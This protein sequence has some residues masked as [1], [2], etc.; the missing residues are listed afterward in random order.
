M[1]LSQTFEIEGY[2]KK[3]EVRE[4]T[5]KE[6]IDLSKDEAIDKLSVDSLKEL[7]STRLLPLCSN[8]EM[9]ELLQMAPSEIA[10]IWKNFEEVNKVFFEV[11]RKAGVGQ[12]LGEIKKAITAD[13]LSFAATSSKP[14][15]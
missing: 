1:R 14:V 8:I 2:K 7:F 12:T 10:E 13:F 3:F 6:I 4:L 15:T 5:V 11:A 9:D